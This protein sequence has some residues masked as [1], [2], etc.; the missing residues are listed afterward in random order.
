L[1][2]GIDAMTR[3]TVAAIAE[4]VAEM[5]RRLDAVEASNAELQ[6]SAKETHDKVAE[7]HTALMVARPGEDYGLLHRMG[8]VATAIESGERVA[9]WAVK[10][11]SVLAAIGVIAASIRLGIWPDSR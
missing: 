5:K 6:K 2:A 3:P 8:K 9:G 10:I 4:D 11:A 1:A 7:M